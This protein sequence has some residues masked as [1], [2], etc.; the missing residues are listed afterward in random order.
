MN[1]WTG[2]GR[3]THDPELK[4]TGA[5]KELCRFRIAVNDGYGENRTTTFLTIVTFGKT[6][7][8]VSDYCFKGKEV[9][10]NGRLQINE[11]EKKDGGTG[12]S[13]EIIANQVDFMSDSG[14]KK[15]PPK[16][17]EVEAP[18]GFSQLDDD[19]VPF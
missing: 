1:N 18:T 16:Q 5:G 13:V 6:A 7:K 9:C 2:T 14:Q 3:C 17:E 19:D 8:A 4:I 11:Y 10:V 12:T 15:A